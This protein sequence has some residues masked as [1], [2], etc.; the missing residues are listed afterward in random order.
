MGATAAYAL[1]GSAAP[2]APRRGTIEA[3]SDGVPVLIT[4]H[5]SYLM[6]LR[7]GA[8]EAKAQYSSD[9]GKAARQLSAGLKDMR[10]LDAE[11]SVGLGN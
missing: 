9:L 10:E 1:T 3:T 7:D 6:R 4:Y 11:S 5:P 2:I 8:E